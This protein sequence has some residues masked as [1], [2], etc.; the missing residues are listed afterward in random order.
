MQILES[1]RRA[2]HLNPHGGKWSPDDFEEQ[3]LYTPDKMEDQ[4]VVCSVAVVIF[5][6]LNI[7]FTFPVHSGAKTKTEWFIM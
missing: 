6:K 3:A 4:T 1:Q 7:L 2:R 5:Q